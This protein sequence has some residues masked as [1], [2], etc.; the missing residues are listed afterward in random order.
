MAFIK[1]IRERI[2]EYFRIVLR[3]VRDCVPK[4]VGYFLVQKSQ[5]KLQQ[6]LWHRI[7]SNERIAGMLGEPPSVTE[8]R[9]QLSATIST[10]R[11][12][13]KVIQRDPDITSAGMDG[14]DGELAQ[15]LR[16]MQLEE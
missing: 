12:A 16:R 4:Q 1:E 14:A 5:D 6:D 7:N 15:E 3:S 11:N 8:R 10:L 13:L 9:K 2:D